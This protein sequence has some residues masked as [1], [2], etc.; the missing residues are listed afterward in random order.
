MTTTYMVTMPREG[1]A[2]ISRVFYF[3]RR[4][5]VHKWIVGAEV[6]AGGYKHWQIR[7]K[8]RLEPKD[9]LLAW[10]GIVSAKAHIEEAT[11]SA[12]AWE[13]EGKEGGFLASWDTMGA[14]RA[15]FGRKEWRQ[16]A[17]VEA[18]RD[19]NDREIVVWYDQRGNCGKSWLTAHLYERGEAYLC[20]S[21][22]KDVQAM[23]Q[24]LASQVLADREKGY[25]PRP[26][27]IIDIPRSWKWSE[28][29]YVALE[30]I[31]DGL[32]MDPRYSTRIVDVRGIKVLVLTNTRPKL[33]KLSQDRWA[34][35]EY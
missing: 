11:D 27:V 26:Y 17:I 29:L 1:Y 20:L 9:F 35:Y 33:D 31:K 23:V 2:P 6:G 34:I 14:R 12:E 3:L 19:S 18:L 8:C 15:R 22:M 10:Q 25:A 30:A 32:I 7:L 24:S 5:D 21:Y 13:Y 16:E 4:F 28:Q